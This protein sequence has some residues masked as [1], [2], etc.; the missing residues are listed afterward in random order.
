MSPD[1]VVIGLVVEQDV[2]RQE[3]ISLGNLCHVLRIVPAAPKRWRPALIEP[4]VVKVVKSHIQRETD[5]SPW[6]SIG[7][8]RPTQ[9][10]MLAQS[11]RIKLCKLRPFL[12]TDV[13]LSRILL[14]VAY[15]L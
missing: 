1:V 15:E 2:R 8:A 14:T 3:T 7:S 12:G 4:S 9:L 5:A 10:A 13:E 6:A 11:V